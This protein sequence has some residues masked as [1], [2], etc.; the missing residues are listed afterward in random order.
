MQPL[1]GSGILLR[2]ELFERA[3]EPQASQRSWCTVAGSNDEDHVFILLAN[4]E[5][6]MGP[7]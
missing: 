1:L 3:L 4:E 6:Q 5:V 2:I 7:D